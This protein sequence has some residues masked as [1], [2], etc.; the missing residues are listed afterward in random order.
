MKE[1]TNRY[2]HVLDLIADLGGAMYLI[3]ALMGLIVGPFQDYSHLV[4][5]LSNLYLARS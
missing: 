1:H 4:S 3:I 5:L 2:Y